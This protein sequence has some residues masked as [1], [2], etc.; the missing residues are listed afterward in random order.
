MSPVVNALIDVLTEMNFLTVF[1]GYA[2]IL[3]CEY[4]YM[5]SVS[6]QV[7]PN[8]TRQNQSKSIHFSP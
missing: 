2:S 8:T 7:K 5:Y 6:L 1:S 3:F 4:E